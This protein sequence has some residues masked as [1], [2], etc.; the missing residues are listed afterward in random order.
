MIAFL[1]NKIT[2]FFVYKKIVEKENKDIYQYGFEMLLSSLLTVFIV[3]II[4]L[5][6]NCLLEAC[7]FYLVFATIRSYSGGF[8][9]NTYL[10]C[11]ITFIIVLLS[12][13]SLSF[14]LDNIILSIYSVI[15]IVIFNILMLLKFAPIENKNKPIKDSDIKKHKI[16]S[17][18][19]NIFWLITAI[20]FSFILN[21]RMFWLIIITQFA[22]SV[23][24]I[25]NI[26]LEN[27]SYKI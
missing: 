18:L 1:G 11:K 23:L 4:G 17:V 9:A 21:D 3:V 25:I 26:M 12:V 6:F 8:H 22:I 24:I 7:V 15:P 5:F 14:I 20:I 13:L 19:L 27:K 16:K 10:K 2:D